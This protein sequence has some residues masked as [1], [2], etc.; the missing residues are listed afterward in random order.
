[1]TGVIVR[2]I[3]RSFNSASNGNV[4]IFDQNRIIKSETVVGTTA[5]KNGIFLQAS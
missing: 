2:I 1:M 3:K 4:V 5:C